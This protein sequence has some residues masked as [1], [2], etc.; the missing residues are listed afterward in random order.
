MYPTN[1]TGTTT[2][3]VLA[4]VG[5]CWPVV[6]IVTIGLSAY[7]CK[8]SVTVSNE[9][10]VPLSSLEVNPGTLQPSFSGNTS[11]YTVEAPTAA[12]SITVTA[13]PKDTAATMTING[14]VTAAGQGRSVPLGPPGS[15]AAIPIALSSQTGG[16]SAYTV[17][18]TRLLSSDN[19]LSALTV[20][21]GSLSPDFAPDQFPIR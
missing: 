6:L 10:Q 13:S 4:L 18:V 16:E 20:T 19:N 1:M 15:T 14:T 17:T 8:D 2:E 11:N 12:D 21:S 7:G 3:R 5:P 9:P